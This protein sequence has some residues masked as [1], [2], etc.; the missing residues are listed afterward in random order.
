MCFKASLSGMT[1]CP[2]VMTGEWGE[3]FSNEVETIK[4]QNNTRRWTAC[5]LVWVPFRWFRQIGIH[6]GIREG[7]MD[8][9]ALLCTLSIQF[10]L[11]FQG[12]LSSVGLLRND[13]LY[14]IY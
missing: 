6:Y 13:D 14:C 1:D 9:G 10:I 3:S 12:Y 4:P 7:R 8:G 11:H 5:W 2:Q